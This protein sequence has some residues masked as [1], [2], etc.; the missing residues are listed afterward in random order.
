MYS[1]VNALYEALN[2]Y[3]GCVYTLAEIISK[4]DLVLSLTV[5][6]A[7]H[8]MV[9]PRFGDQMKVVNGKHPILLL[10][11]ADG[12]EQREN[13]VVANDAV[14]TLSAELILIVFN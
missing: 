1:T 6:S 9:P 10:M 11:H 7:K 13:R 4:L 5:A 8:A 12:N 14:S 2:N 3:I